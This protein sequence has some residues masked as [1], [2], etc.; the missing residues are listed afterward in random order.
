MSH[1]CQT[2]TK[3]KRPEVVYHGILIPCLSGRMELNSE[4][5]GGKGSFLNGA[6]RKTSSTQRE[7]QT[8]G[9]ERSPS[10]AKSLFS[11]GEE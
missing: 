1:L 3:V 9:R 8:H 2:R 6:K 11:L 5:E 10:T 7:L 4:S